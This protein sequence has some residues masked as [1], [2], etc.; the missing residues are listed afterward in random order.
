MP[1]TIERSAGFIVYVD[2]DAEHAERLYLLL[3]Y[4][5]HWDYAKG[6]VEKSEDDLTAAIREL[7][8][9]TGIDD[10]EPITG[11]SHELQYFFRHP[12]RGLIKKTVI[13]F[14]ARARDTHVE[15]SHEHET[16]AWLPLPQALKRLTFP[17]ARKALELAA[18]FLGDA[19][20]PKPKTKKKAVKKKKSKEK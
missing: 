4:G 15:V 9:E 13:F 16:Y 1:L 20:P 5:K 10:A 11:F 2:P 18:T 8:E 14:L 7:E 6:H 12:K 3:D 17:N 19:V